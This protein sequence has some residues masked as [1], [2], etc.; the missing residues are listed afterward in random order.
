MVEKIFFDSL[1]RTAEEIGREPLLF[2]KINTVELLNTFDK[3]TIDIDYLFISDICD[4]LLNSATILNMLSNCTGH[5]RRPIEMKA[6][7]FAKGR[8]LIKIC[9]L[10]PYCLAV[11]LKTAKEDEESEQE[12]ANFMSIR[13]TE[14]VADDLGDIFN[15]LDSLTKLGE[16]PFRVVKEKLI[17][18]I[19][20]NRK[21]IIQFGQKQQISAFANLISSLEDNCYLELALGIEMSMDD[22]IML[23]SSEGINIGKSFYPLF[24]S[25][26]AGSILMKN[27]DLLE[28]IDNNCYRICIY[29]TSF[30][31]RKAFKSKQQ[32]SESKNQTNLDLISVTQSKFLE[33]LEKYEEKLI[34]QWEKSKLR[35]EGYFHSVSAKSN[36]IVTS[37][38]R[39]SS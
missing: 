25:K 26:Q 19:P 24:L 39:A 33:L 34:P 32:L 16:V 35:Y 17:E 29:N 18:L 13:E 37:R 23:A 21:A 10:R 7:R 8:K 22:Q 1:L 38:Y 5:F 28:I 6:Y 4:I 15:Y 36:T 12:D 20:Q 9:N 11:D 3:A 27:D 30:H 31:E 14:E 2:E